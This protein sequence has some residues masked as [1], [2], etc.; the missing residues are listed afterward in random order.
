MGKSLMGCRRLCSVGSLLR[1]TVR[2]FCHICSAEGAIVGDGPS[3]P[4][5]FGG[6]QNAL[7]RD[8]CKC[9]CSLH[10]DS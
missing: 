5:S 6:K 10:R 4:V 2:V 9:K 8:I 3:L 7:E 1:V